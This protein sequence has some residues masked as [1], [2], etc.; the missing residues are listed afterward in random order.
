MPDNGNVPSY[1][2]RTAH[3]PAYLSDVAERPDTG[4][5]SREESCPAF[6]YLRGLQDSAVAV[7]F[8]FRDGNSEW[9]A[10][11]CLVSFR[12]DPSAGLLLK[13][14]GDVVTLV[15]VSG[16]NL[17]APVGQGM[18]NL[19]DRGLQ[20][21]RIVWVRE[22]DEA[23]LRQVGESGPTIDRIDIAEFET[24]EERR[25]WLKKRA[26]AFVRPSR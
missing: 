17:D 13:F 11:S 12:H 18:V 2:N 14:T 15:L 7:E 24:A 22:M 1:I 25:E 4:T 20:R 23:E 8:R 26:P 19:T 21:H 3:R 10:Y 6:G 9:F 16:S 5:D